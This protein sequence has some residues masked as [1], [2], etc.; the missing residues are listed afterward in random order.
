M[1]AELHLFII[2]Q[3]ARNQSD[4]ILDDLKRHF[5]IRRVYELQWSEAHF[6]S[7]ISRFY[8]QKLPRDSY[9]ETH[10]G[11]GPFL[12]IVVRDN[13]PHYELRATSRGEA[14]VN[15][16]CFDSKERYRELTGG[17][18]RIHGT[19]SPGETDHD[20]VLL[21]QLTAAEFES[22]CSDPWNGEVEKLE[23]DLAGA[24]GWRSLTELFHV[25]NSAIPYAV[26]RN[27]EGL[28]EA[29][30]LP[31]HG[32]IDL[33][34][35]NAQEMAFIANATPLF[36]EQFRVLHQVS[37]AGAPLLFDFR[38]VG[39]HYY[40]PA[41]ERD[42]LARRI[43]SPKGFYHLGSEDHFYS[44]LYHA[45]VH[46]P[47]IAADY[48]ARLAT[49]SSGHDTYGA[50][51]LTTTEEVNKVLDAYLSSHDYRFVEPQ[52]SSVYFNMSV[53]RL[54][55]LSLTRIFTSSRNIG[56]ALQRLF[57]QTKD[58]STNSPE[59]NDAAYRSRELAVYF[60]MS[61]GRFVQALNLPRDSKVLQA[62]VD[63]GV[64]SRT[65]GETF[66][67]VTVLEA[68]AD[69]ARAT[70]ARC[71]DLS[72]VSVRN[73]YL[74]Q[75]GGG[76]SFDIAFTDLGSSAKE[77][78]RFL[79]KA[80]R[81]SGVLVLGVGKRNPGGDGTFTALRD[82][83]IDLLKANGFKAFRIFYPFPNLET[84]RVVFS[85]NAVR[86]AKK[87]FGYWAAFA[88][89][90]DSRS[91]PMGEF[92]AAAA[93]SEGRLD[94]L[95]T[96]CYII[97]A[98]DEAALP[99]VS[100]DVWASSAE[101]RHPSLRALTYVEREDTSFAVRKC[102][103]PAA[104]GV[105][106]FHPEMETPLFEGHTEAAAL[107]YA[108]QN[109][110]M[111]QFLTLQKLHAKSLLREFQFASNIDYPALLVEGDI[112]LRGVA[113]DAIP[114]NTVME[115]NEYRIFDLEWGVSTP[116][117]MSFILFRGLVVLFQKTHPNTIYNR[118]RLDRYG[119]AANPS[120]HALAA[121]F[122]NSLDLFSPFNAHS[123]KLVAAF[124]RR[125]LEFA[126]N[127]QVPAQG[128][129]L[130]EL[131]HHAIAQ[132][133]AGDRDGYSRTIAEMRAAYPDA[134]EP[135]RLESAL[136]RQEELLQPVG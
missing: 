106:R 104:S 10:C 52:D 29:A 33:L 74:D 7:N 94:S 107:R 5:E 120:P 100:W 90:D 103:T 67:Q 126:A 11:R 53:A 82:F 118:L 72:T 79:E 89:N 28:P 69:L 45:A 98:K 30:T 109:G 60:N 32:D 18:H 50:Q 87:S 39:D 122:L 92:D 63:F 136:I 131:Y 61:R 64:L 91:V 38:F 128:A 108:L 133:Q 127:G 56:V 75:L 97:A 9:K 51:S 81:K 3:N 135:F 110:A 20:L 1:A 124:E 101:A 86:E 4:V 111:D 73:M 6:S 24:E 54:T 85:D 102:G 34:C 40:D 116:L 8:G 58:C 44:L 47:S 22:T 19:T 12:L 25:L 77:E 17:G 68:D 130:F 121:F 35:S 83:S 76:R 84:P 46:K 80:V 13:A 43:H 48:A 123:M 114:Q 59:F 115:G 113:M 78:I 21:L 36:R 105:F 49:L 26:L 16:R 55:K 99:N 15:T 57:G 66:S 23:Q 71:R 96:S 112:L 31:G 2:W 62:G 88:S 42:M 132:H 41:W 27:F 95:A 65:L 37:V 14:V 129:S 70:A 125:F 117:P 93:S 134:A 119:L